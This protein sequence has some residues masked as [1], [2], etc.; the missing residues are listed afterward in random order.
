MP[1]TNRWCGR[2]KPRRTV[3]SLDDIPEKQKLFILTLEGDT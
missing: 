3:Q 1:L 2:K